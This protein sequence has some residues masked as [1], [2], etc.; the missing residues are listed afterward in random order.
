MSN[1]NF[2]LYFQFKISTFHNDF[3]IKDSENRT[4]FYVRQKLFK[5]KEEI[6]IFADESRSEQLYGIKA[7]RWLDFNANYTITDA[8][9]N[10]TIGKIGRKGMKSLW[11]ANYNAFDSAGMEDY[12]IKEDNAWIKVGDNLLGEI[13]ILNILTGYIFNPSYSL[14]DKRE[15][16]LL[17][18]LKK[19]SFFSR[20]FT[21]EKLADINPEDE[22]RLI[23]CFMMM[24]LLERERG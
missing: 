10:E 17:Q 15:N 13:P 21:L 5:L 24:I 14:Y 12:L 6:M 8:R 18:L 3:T 23:L 19:P 20:K 7:D 9:T 22:T 11:K 2:P 1:F 16:V 4:L